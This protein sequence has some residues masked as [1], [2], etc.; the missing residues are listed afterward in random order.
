MGMRGGHGGPPH[1][2]N[3]GRGTAVSGAP[4]GYCHKLILSKLSL[5]LGILDE[6]FLQLTVDFHKH[7]GVFLVF[8]QGL[9]NPDAV[10]AAVK[11]DQ[12]LGWRLAP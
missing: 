1:Q 8:G 2:K 3:Q 4:P 11:G 5:L 12:G 7:R 6:K 10:G 9:V